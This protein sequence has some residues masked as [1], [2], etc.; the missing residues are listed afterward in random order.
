MADYT[1]EQYLEH[2][3]MITDGL[4]EMA[5]AAGRTHFTRNM[6]LRECYQ[7]VGEELHTQAEWEEMGARIKKGENGYLFWTVGQEFDF[8]FYREQVIFDE[9]Q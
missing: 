8:F 3:Q 4:T 7:L 5:Q 9:I 1:K 2:L 6:L